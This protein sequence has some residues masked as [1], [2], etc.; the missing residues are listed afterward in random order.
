MHINKVSEPVE[1]LI[2]QTYERRNLL[3]SEDFF[4]DPAWLILLC[5]RTGSVPLDMA[6]LNTATGVSIALLRRWLSVLTGHGYVQALNSSAGVELY[7]LTNVATEKL[8][9]VFTITPT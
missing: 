6:G 4:H 1:V 3:F 7:A 2:L 9:Q 8:D 5:L